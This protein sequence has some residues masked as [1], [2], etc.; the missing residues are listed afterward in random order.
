MA[1]MTIRNIV[2]ALKSRLRIPAAIHGRSVVDD[3]RDI[4]RAELSMETLGARDLGRTIRA[5]IPALGGVELP[6][7]PREPIREPVD[8]SR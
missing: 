2:D 1:T 6:D 5:R 7:V 4:L 8:F 3:A